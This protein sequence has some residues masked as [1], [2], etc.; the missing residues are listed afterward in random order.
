MAP[1]RNPSPRRIA[2][3]ALVAALIGAAAVAAQDPLPASG[4]RAASA[5]EIDEWQ[6]ALVRDARVGFNS[7]TGPAALAALEDPLR[8]PDD[9]A[10]ALMALGASGTFSARPTLELSASEGERVERLGAVFGL[11]ELGPHLGPGQTL[12]VQLLKDPDKL[13]AGC[14][15][16]AL[17]RSGEPQ[18]PELALDMAF[19]PA[20]P[21]RTMAPALVAFARDPAGAPSS[22]PAARLLELRFE[23]A[24]LFGTVDGQAWSVSLVVGLLADEVFVDRLVLGAAVEVELPGVR[25]HLLEI[26]LQPGGP[27]RVGAAV[28]VMPLELDQLLLHGLWSPAGPEEWEALLEAAVESGVARLMPTALE[29]ATRIPSSAATAA[30]FLVERDGRY[31]ELVL[32]GLGSED[33]QAC[34]RAAR[35]AGESGE[36]RFL[37]GLSSLE[38][39]P[40]PGVAAAAWAARL[41]LGDALAAAHLRRV[42]VD[43]PGDL[44]DTGDP[45]AADAADDRGGALLDALAHGSP[46]PVV[47][48]FL[49][50]L[51]DDLQGLD[52]A[53]VLALLALRGRL[54]DGAS[55]REHYPAAGPG[56]DGARRLLRALA[57]FP[58]AQDLAFLAGLFPLEDDLETNLVLARALLRHGHDA[59][60][61]VLKG[62]VWSGPLHRSL[63]AAAVVKENLGM[64]VLQHWAVKPP[65]TASVEDIRRVGFAIGEWGGIAALEE[66]RARMGAVAG[67]DR[68]ALQGA[69]MGALAARTH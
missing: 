13:V 3:P 56:S 61:P 25:D 43:G 62:A 63:L 36:L 26:L 66:L 1:F 41:R 45:D 60:V 42:L 44:G 52:R 35:A 9:R 69:L 50:T 22:L 15:M 27:Q 4:E 2:P 21:L 54:V 8:S 17:L 51:V 37:S 19:G 16:L 46:A 24:K 40:R 34:L 10:A 48:D 18:G 33:G 53:R 30:A 32:A 12:L 6:A 28:R 14:A 11:G 67:A 7:R 55:L 65:A 39:D 47:T 49:A 29:H 20:S 57:V 38:G 58:S 5:E 68:P 64:R 59:L 31:E 23:A